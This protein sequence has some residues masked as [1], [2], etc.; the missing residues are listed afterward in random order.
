MAFSDGMTALPAGQMVEITAP[1]QFGYDGDFS[2]EHKLIL[3][4]GSCSPVKTYNS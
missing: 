4:A 3:R 2:I 1:G